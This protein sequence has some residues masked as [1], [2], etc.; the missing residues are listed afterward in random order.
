MANESG[1]GA[2]A[3]GGDRPNRDRFPDLGV[4]LNDDGKPLSLWHHR[5][6]DP[7]ARSSS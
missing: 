7:F 4:S 6:L 5:R 1:A 3:G 2:H